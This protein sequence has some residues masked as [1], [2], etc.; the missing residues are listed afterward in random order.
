M[1]NKDKTKEQLLEEIDLLKAQIA[2]FEKSE[3]ARQYSEQAIPQVNKELQENAKKYKDLF[4]KS[5]DAIL[6]LQNGIFVDCNNATIKMLRYHSKNEFLNKHPSDLS[7][8]KQEDGQLSISKEAKMI[9]IAFKHGSY[10]FEWNHKKADGEIFPVEVLLT[11]IE[12]EEDNKVLH[13]V[14]R[15]ITDRKKA[16]KEL[17]QSEERFRRL[18]DDLGD[19]VFVTRIGKTNMGEIVEVNSAAVRQT[20]YSRVELLQMNIIDDLAIAET[21]EIDISDWNEKLFAG[22]MVTTTEKKRRKDGSEFWTEVIVTPIEFKGEVA[23]LSINHDITNRKL[24]ED[25]LKKSEEH[26]RVLF[27]NT[28]IGFYR[29][30][31]EGKIILA[32]PA[33]VAM[34]G[35]RDLDELTQRNLAEDSLYTDTSRTKI[36]ELINRTGYLKGHESSW[37][38]KNNETV[39]VRENAKAFYDSAGKII[40]YEGTI[41]DI[42]ETKNAALLLKESEEK[43]RTLI[44]NIQDGVFIINEKKI[45][46]VNEA[47]ASIIG[48][49]KEDVFGM[50]FKK[51]IAPEDWKMVLGNYIRRMK[52]GAPINNFEFR[53][54][55]KDGVTQVYVNMTIDRIIYENKAVAFGTVKDISEN[56]KMQEKLLLR[57]QYYKAL[58]D[59]SPSGIIVL[60]TDGT[61]LDIND[62]F[63]KYNGYTP[64]ELQNKNVSILANEE[65]E[66]EINYQA[67]LHGKTLKHEVVNIAK[68]GSLRNVELYETKVMLPDGQYGI[69]SIANDITERTR[70]AKMQKV[71]YKIAFAVNL[72]DNLDELISII[73]EGLGTL[74]DTTNFFVAIYEEETNTILLPYM[75]DKKD[76]FTSFPAG[77]S[78]T[79]YVIKTKKPLFATKEV[80]AELEAS[81]K[82]ESFGSDSEIWLGV[83]MILN[84]KVTGAIVVQS[85]DDEKAYNLNDLEILEFVS[86]SIGLA[87][88]RKKAEQDLISALEM[89][90]ESDRLKSTFLT[91]MSHELRTPLNAIIGFSE[92]IDKDVPLDEILEFNKTI[93]SSGLHL[94]D[95]VEDI[96]DITL[97][98]TGEIQIEKKEERLKSILRNIDEIIKIE[99]LNIDKGNIAINQILPSETDQLIIYTDKSKFKQILINLLKNALK[100]THEGQV[101][102][103][104]TVESIEGRSM[105]KFFVED[106]GIGIPKDKQS[107][108]FEMFRQVEESHTRVYGGTGIGLS[109]SKKLAELLGGEL[110]V[111]SDSENNRSGSIFYFTIPNE[112]YTIEEKT[113][114]IESI[115]IS[116]F[117]KKTVLVVEDDEASFEFLK[118]V[119]GRLGINTIWAKSGREAIQVCKLRSDIDLVLMDIN[120]P[121]MNGYDATIEIKKIKPNLK[122]IA[123]T[124][125]AISGDRRKALDVG[126]DDY[127]SKPIDKTLF[128]EMIGKYL[129]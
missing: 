42:S 114:Q 101:N 78:L 56:K 16:E 77:K 90:K 49:T 35:Y 127:I 100:F 11:V 41:E 21:E 25:K 60:D 23:S 36:L 102:Y 15:D 27:E 65:G 84:G 123:Q 67:L 18:F 91:T 116:K 98:E 32:N 19:A 125:Y 66:I 47:F 86:Q 109:I 70:T 92:I 126:C 5:K 6:V 105:L 51:I 20:G 111:E 121:E 58:F 118:I 48:Y 115:K 28:S 68:D 40:Y 76:N 104:F 31:P 71:I 96:F 108:I 55:H 3:S 74:I 120:M 69:L 106:T 22:K 95:I 99:Q 9:E 94:L 14:W 54:L 80:L 63:C 53:A 119:L 64:A 85:Y 4:E 122:V 107:L 45:L 82:I 87:I 46:F 33:L 8:E 7:P 89:A 43:Y 93:N 52:G 73:R 88:S 26:F 34:L 10:R 13:T 61:I 62:S 57:E 37:K 83:P 24:A 59:L 103:G 2:R 128:T 17:K 29:T 112:R 113:E 124:A 39:F 129:N 110:W 72:T 97:I 1:Q 75:V 30:T 12:N 50:D 81:G 44:E 79:S 117:D 38:I